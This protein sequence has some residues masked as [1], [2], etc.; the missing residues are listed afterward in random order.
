MIVL[1]TDYGVDDIYVAQVKAALLQ[2]LPAGNVIIDLLHSVPNFHVRSGAHLL[3][4]LQGRFRVG[5]VFLTV[6]DPDVGTDRDAVILQADGKSYVGPDNG[7]LSVVAA[8]ATKTQT[9]RIIWRPPMLSASFHGRDLFAPVA[10]WIA[11]GDLLT[12]ESEETE[13]LQV[14]FGPHDL[15]EV[16]YIDHYGNALTGLRA[17][18]VPRSAMI[19]VRERRVPYARVFADAPAGSAFWYEN[20]IGVVELAA[21]RTSAAGLLGIGVGDSVGVIAEIVQ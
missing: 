7:L 4:A 8:R 16:I 10:A 17:R 1:F 5:T 18:N 20:S 3:A 13:Q 21:N 12:D 2:H 19:S 11:R 14:H 15:S 6:V 9:R